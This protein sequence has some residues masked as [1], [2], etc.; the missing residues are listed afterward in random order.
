[1]RVTITHTTRLDYSAEVVEAV[2]D[3]RVGPLSDAHQRWDIYEIGA[4]PSAAVR[5]YGDGFGNVAHLVT[6]SRPHRHVEVVTRGEV[7]VLL[8]DPFAL[9][10]G[11]IRPLM[12][13]ELHDYLSPSTLIPRFAELDAL[14]T[15]HRPSDPQGTFEA[16]QR[17]MTDV[18]RSFTYR[19]DVT[20]VATTVPEVLKGRT[21]VCQDFA[22][23][24]TGLCRA[25]DI[26][27][28]YVSGYIVA[29][30][31]EMA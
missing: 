20:T 11:S 16:V 2:M 4:S 15:P 27:A 13:A 28:R 10:I 29:D 12:P 30:A 18:Y 21:G 26:P 19:K 25:I 3:M 9:P 6:V 24:L 5:R 8:E 14:A 22:H 1:M 31:P 7:D 23:L 17:L